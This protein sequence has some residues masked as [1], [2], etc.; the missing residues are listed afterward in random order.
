MRLKLAA[1]EIEQDT[2]A[3]QRN[4]VSHLMHSKE[5]S[6]GSSFDPTR[7]SLDATKKHRQGNNETTGAAAGILKTGSSLK[8]RKD[9]DQVKSATQVKM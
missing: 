9:L 5:E 3:R 1:E 7:S 6:T 4:K 2:M 8:T